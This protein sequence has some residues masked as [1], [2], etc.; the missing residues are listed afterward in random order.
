MDDILSQTG[1]AKN[2]G[3][4]SAKTGSH[5]ASTVKKAGGGLSQSELD[6][7]RRKIQRNWNVPPNMDSVVS[8][9]FELDESGRVIGGS[10]GI[11]LV[12]GPSSALR[13]IQAAVMASQPFN[14][15]P[16]EKYET[17]GNID[18]SFSN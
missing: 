9:S 2:N 12:S 4:S 18:L 16:A 10:K 8:V 3:G 1:A 7:L 13:S 15:L 14:E 17:W 6:G 5:S 11:R